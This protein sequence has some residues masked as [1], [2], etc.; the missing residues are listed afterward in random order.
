M[1][2]LCCCGNAASPT[3][4]EADLTPWTWTPSIS[5]QRSSLTGYYYY[6]DTYSLEKN[7][8]CPA[9]QQ[10]KAQMITSSAA[11]A[12]SEPWRSWV[13]WIGFWGTCNSAKLYMYIEPSKNLATTHCIC[14]G[15]FL[16]KTH[17]SLATKSHSGFAFQFEAHAVSCMA[18]ICSSGLVYYEYIL[19]Y[20]IYIWIYS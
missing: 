15:V 18:S 10:S 8:C 4:E 7:S 3:E 6:V 11:T 17:Y 20:Y 16:E 14:S 13:T 12:F 19:Y 9:Q 1:G 5:M 2:W